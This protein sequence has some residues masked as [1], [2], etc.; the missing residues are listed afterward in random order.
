MKLSL[1]KTALVLC[2][3]LAGNS[4]MADHELIVVPER[5]TGHDTDR[6][7][8]RRSDKR[9]R[10]HTNQRSEREASTYRR[11]YLT[12]YFGG[13]FGAGG[14]EVGR[15]TDNFGD[16]ERVRSGGGFHF[17]GGLLTALDP[18]T[19]LRL[20]AGYETDWAGRTNGRAAFSRTRFDLMALRNFGPFDLGIGL[21]AHVGV[22]FD[23]SIDSICAGDQEYDNALGYTVEYA[24]TSLNQNRYFGSRRDKRL[25]PLRNARI[26]LR[27]TD[28]EYTPVFG[29]TPPSGSEV[30]DGK[31]LGIFVGFAM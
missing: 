18:Y 10:R 3:L 11:P 26:G 13:G 31:S 21:T 19:M 27:F 14:D 24:L 6:H 9:N 16:T 15:F 12:T 20:T 29:S 2:T 28:I 23:C 17:E 5:H 8:D 4:V 30:L 22:N 7:S 1:F 25:H